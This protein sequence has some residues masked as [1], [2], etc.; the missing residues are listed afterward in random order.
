MALIL[1]DADH[2]LGEPILG[3][4]QVNQIYVYNGQAF[5]PAAVGDLES[6]REMA[7][8]IG[9]ALEKAGQAMDKSTQTQDFLDQIVDENGINIPAL[10]K[11]ALLCA[12]QNVQLQSLRFGM[13]NEQVEGE[14]VNG[15]F[16]VF[17]GTQSVDMGVS[18]AL[19]HDDKGM[20]TSH[21]L[22]SGLNRSLKI[23]DPS[24]MERVNLQ[25]EAVYWRQDDSETGHF[26]GVEQV[27]VDASLNNRGDGKVG[28]PALNHGLIPGQMVRFYGFNYPAYNSAHV[29]DSSSTASE[30]V[31]SA[32]FVA[33]EITPDC[34][35]RKILSVGSSGDCPGIETGM[36]MELES[37]E[38]SIVWIDETTQGR[39]IGKIALDL[40]SP[41]QPIKSISGI[42]I[43]IEG[44]GITS[45][46]DFLGSRN[47]SILD[48]V[49][50]LTGSE[51]VSSSSQT[52]NFEAYKVFDDHHGTDFR[53]LSAANNTS[54]WVCY[55]FGETAR[56]IN[57]YRWRTFESASSSVPGAWRL[58][59]S[60]DNQ[61]WTVLHEGSNSV[62]TA[63]TWIPQNAEGYFSFYNS[64]AYRYYRFFVTANCGHPQYLCIDEIEL[65]EA[66]AKV[67]PLSIMALISKPQLIPDI[68]QW[69]SIESMDI[70]ENKPG[71]SRI[72][73]AVTFDGGQ[74]WS[75]FKDSSWQEIT[76]IVSGQWYFRNAGNSW[77]LVEENTQ[78]KALQRAFGVQTNQMTAQEFEQLGPD[79]WSLP[80]TW[81]S[82]TKSFQFAAGLQSDGLDHPLIQNISISYSTKSSGLIL[83]SMPKPIRPNSQK[84]SASLLLKNQHDS[85]KL[86]VF[87]SEEDGWVE[88]GH[89]IEAANFGNGIGFFVTSEI[90]VRA[91]SNVRLKVECESS[92]GLELYGWALNGW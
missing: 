32:I 74:S 71:L 88:M 15:F 50:G 27:F 64:R 52:T 65:I 83:V 47:E 56:V 55:D 37:S 81:N 19:Y 26:E 31:V 34:R 58:E 35:Y 24:L 42:E 53:W 4:P 1:G 78:I 72:F 61:N 75:V 90:P 86:Y 85:L 84:V 66:P 76:R 68:A 21:D 6:V 91:N 16:S 51:N 14:L 87:T 46:H 3:K 28:F 80:G 77:E 18:N 38:R 11:D 2:L 73:Y 20:F 40:P 63:N 25:G 12:I 79:D 60:N 54:G 39:G 57:K 5:V 62:Q 23:D 36:Q 13:T 49:P 22:S 89:L 10:E 45:G 48:A 17:R 30:I 9:E 7:E 59:A 41:S 29:V 82:T 33:E 44:I 8:S 70:S 92:H 69:H 43:G 67:F